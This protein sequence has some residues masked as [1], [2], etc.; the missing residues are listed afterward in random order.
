[1]TALFGGK[2]KGSWSWTEGGVVL[3]RSEGVVPKL[4]FGS[5]EME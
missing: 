5:L 1:V 4:D 2:K 3:G